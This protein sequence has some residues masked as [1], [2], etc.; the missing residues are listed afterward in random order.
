VAAA[1]YRV[2]LARAGVEVAA[3]RERVDRFLAADEWIVRRCVR[4]K[5]GDKITAIDVRAMVEKLAAEE[6][7]GEARLD[8]VLSRRSGNLGRPKEL[9][10]ALFDLSGDRVLDVG[11]H[12]LDSFVEFDGALVSAGAGWAALDRFDPWSNREAPPATP[13]RAA[14]R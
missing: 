13:S 5:R 6:V 4:K 14:A 1:R 2:S 9:L 10:L 8:V 12:K 11:V 3:A 7:D